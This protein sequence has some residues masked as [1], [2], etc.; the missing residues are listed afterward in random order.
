MRFSRLAKCKELTLCCF[1]WNQ[2]QI[3]AFPPVVEASSVDYSI[4][5]IMRVSFSANY[6][7]PSVIQCLQPLDN[8]HI[9]YRIATEQVDKYVSIYIYIYTVIEPRARK[10]DAGTNC[11]NTSNQSIPLQRVVFLF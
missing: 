4:H 11:L 5:P 7:D 8:L 9:L 1:C 6:T 2:Q 10:V 3:N